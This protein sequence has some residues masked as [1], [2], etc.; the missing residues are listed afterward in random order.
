MDWLTLVSAQAAPCRAA[1]RKGFPARGARIKMHRERKERW[2]DRW[3]AP[4][5]SRGASPFPRAG[6]SNYSAWRGNSEK[7]DKCTSLRSIPVLA[8]CRSSLHPTRRVQQ[9]WLGSLAALPGHFLPDGYWHVVA[10]PLGNPAVACACDQLIQSLYLDLM[11]VCTACLFS[12][13]RV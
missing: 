6:C 12:L 1:E 2:P 9:T 11:S 10:L 7:E 3:W 8:E 4:R 13:L 5:T